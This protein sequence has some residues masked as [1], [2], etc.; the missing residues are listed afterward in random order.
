ML[1]GS[2]QVAE[3]VNH[4]GSILGSVRALAAIVQLQRFETIISCFDNCR[5]HLNAALSIFRKIVDNFNT[6]VD[7]LDLLYIFFLRERRA[8]SSP[9]KTRSN[10][11]RH[12]LFLLHL[13]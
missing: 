5:A 1:R 6:G 10:Q 12:H 11:H 3:S 7:L 4:D 8:Q 13:Q 9:P 2:I